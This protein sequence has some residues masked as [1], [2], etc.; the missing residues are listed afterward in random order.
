MYGIA[1]PTSTNIPVLRN[2][3]RFNDVLRHR[4]ESSDFAYQLTA[5][6][7]K[8]FS[9]GMELLLAY[10][11]S[12]AEDLFT[13]GSSIANSNYRFTVLD[14]TI[15]NRN[16]RP[17]GFNIPQKITATGI[18]G[19]PGDVRLS[20]VYIGQSGHPFTYVTSTDANGDGVSG[21]DPVYVPRNASDIALAT[22]ADTA[23]FQRIRSEACLRDN[24]GQLLPRNSCSDPW[25][26]IM[27]ARVAKIIPTVRGQSLEISADIFNLLHLLNDNWGV[28][29][30]TSGGPGF[31]NENLLRATGYDIANQRG[32]Y[33]LNTRAPNRPNLTASRW[34]LQ[35]G[36]KYIF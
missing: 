29:K 2:T 25:V 32:R 14:G 27:N 11:Y 7:Q 16:L 34:Q 24:Q 12:H 28:I 6:I 35:I 21:N 31:E 22:P 30:T 1:L 26:N 19:L 4:N 23:L 8:R 15:E 5:E 20:L 13:L 17:S 9:R 10:T 33:T 36:A 3:T 18:F